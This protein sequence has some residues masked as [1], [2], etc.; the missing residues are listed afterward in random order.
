MIYVPVDGAH[1]KLFF[2]GIESNKEERKKHMAVSL[3][4]F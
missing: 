1:S 4:F 2:Q 3:E